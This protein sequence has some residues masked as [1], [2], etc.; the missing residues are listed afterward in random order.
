MSAPIVTERWSQRQYV[1]N[2]SA[3]RAFDVSGVT[4]ETDA[5]NALITQ[6]QVGVNASFPLEPVL[7]V[8]SNGLNITTVTPT[9]YL[10]VAS[11]ARGIAT[12]NSDPIQEPPVYQWAPSSGTAPINTDIDGNAILNSAGDLFSP[13]PSRF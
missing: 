9:M 2:T 5:V 4:N 11:Y 8:A 12:G 3:V 1:P 7:H 6:A 10:I 13:S